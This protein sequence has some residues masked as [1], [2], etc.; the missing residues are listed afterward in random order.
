MKL[1][2]VCLTMLLLAVAVQ[3]DDDISGKITAID[4]AAGTLEISGVKIMAK[5]AAVK[6]LIMPSSLSKLKVG[7]KVAVE[8]TFSGSLKFTARKIEKKLFEHAEIDGTLHSVNAKARTLNI[9]GI[10]VKVPEGAELEGADDNQI[11]LERLPKGKKLEVEG[12][13]T[14]KG[15]FTASSIEVN[16]D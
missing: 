12:E 14:G 4:A 5:D 6:G 10:T 16:Q 15:E 2:G 7:D 3:A 8:G 11:T 9:S 1:L 13:W